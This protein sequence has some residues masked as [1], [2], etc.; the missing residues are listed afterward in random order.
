[1]APVVI[2]LSHK[3]NLEAAAVFYFFL[4]HYEYCPGT[5]C[6]QIT[7]VNVG[8]LR[9]IWEMVYNGRTEVK[10]G[11]RRSASTFCTFVIRVVEI[12]IQ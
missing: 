4:T 9:I 11:N 10:E 2:N 5:A 6:S 3:E 7:L 8:S 12:L 1:M